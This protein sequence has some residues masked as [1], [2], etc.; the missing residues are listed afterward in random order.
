MGSESGYILTEIWN[1]R[2]SWHAL[3]LEERRQ[4]FHE[5]IGPLI[6]SL[7]EQG[8]E[9]LG[10][11]IDD[12]TGPES[13]SC[14]YMAIWKLPEKA[15]SE[16]LEASAKESGFLDYFEQVNFSG[17]IITPD[18]MNADMIRLDGASAPAR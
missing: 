17:R 14:R 3:A 8:A 5:R 1:A 16:R 6:M 11:A 15:L 7:V 9:F 10:C 18:V 13:M 2:P 4:F 12:N